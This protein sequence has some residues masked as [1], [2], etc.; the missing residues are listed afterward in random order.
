MNRNV[1]GVASQVRARALQFFRIGQLREV[2]LFKTFDVVACCPPLLS[3]LGLE[4]RLFS[5]S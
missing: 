5:R 4:T 1:F 3:P 2:P